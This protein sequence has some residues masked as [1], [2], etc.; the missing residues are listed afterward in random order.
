MNPENQQNQEYSI[1]ATDEENNRFA[2]KVGGI[3]IKIRIC[4]LILLTFN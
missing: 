4:L 2:Q 1:V 3:K